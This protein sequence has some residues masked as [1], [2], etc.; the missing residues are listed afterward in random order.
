MAIALILLPTSLTKAA[1][2][3]A[4]SQWWS[5][6]LPSKP[7]IITGFLAPT[8]NTSGLSPA[9]SCSPCLNQRRNRRLDEFLECCKQFRAQRAIH[10][11]MVARQCNSHLVDEFH[12]AI[13]A[14][15]G[16]SSRAA[17]RQ[18]CRVGRIDDRGKFAHAIHAEIGNRAG[19][20]LIFV[21]PE[22]LLARATGEFTH[23]GRNSR[24]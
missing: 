15:D 3:L 17:D 7:F 5:V 19:A 6:T 22:F 12:A 23:L 9:I 4:S 8:I 16:S 21:R 14:L 10:D 24:Q 1:L 13:L 11:A 20:A 18:Y 2:S